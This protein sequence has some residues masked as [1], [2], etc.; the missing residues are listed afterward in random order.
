MVATVPI[1]E[2]KTILNTACPGVPIS[3][4]SVLQPGINLMIISFTEAYVW[5]LSE[6]EKYTQPES[7]YL[8]VTVCN[9]DSDLLYQWRDAVMDALDGFKSGPPAKIRYITSSRPMSSSYDEPNDAGIFEMGFHVF[10]DKNGLT[11]LR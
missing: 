6:T 9:S 10:V 7:F 5:S 1:D 2:I 8:Q 11:P 3:Y 4:A